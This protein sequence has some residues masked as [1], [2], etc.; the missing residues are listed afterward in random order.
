MFEIKDKHIKEAEDLLINGESFETKERTPFV[1]NLDSCDLLAVPGS[2]KTTALLAKLYCLSKHLPFKDGSGILVLSHTNAAVN[3]IE[4]KLKKVIPSLFEYPNFVGTVQSFVNKFLASLAC[5]I[6]YGS[7]ILNNDNDIYEK[8]AEKFFYSLKWKKTEPKALKNKLFGKVN[9]GKDKIT[10]DEK[11]DNIKTFIKYFDLDI[12]KRKIINNNSSFYTYSGSSK[13]YYLELEQWKE[14]LF[15]KGI[16]NYRDSFYIAEWFAENYPLAITILQK[17]F[18]YVF[19]DEMQDLEKYQIDIIDKIFHGD[20]SLT[21]IQRIGDINQSIYNSSKKENIHADWQVR[22]P[23]MYLND[24]YRLTKEVSDVVNFFTLDRQQDEEGNPRFVVNGKRKLDFVIQP[25]LILFSDDTKGQ[26]KNQFAELIK[27]F[28]LEKTKESEKYGF[29]IIGWN[30]KWDDDEDNKG[31]LRLENIFED[32]KKDKTTLKETYDS[33]SKYLQYLDK[34]KKTLESARKAILNALIHIL[35]IE[36]KM[37]TAII[38]GKER[39]RYYTKKELIKH[40]Q[41][42]KNGSDYETFN[43]NLYK[44]SFDLVAKQKYLEVY[45]SIKDFINNDFKNWFRF[46]ISNNTNEFVGENF[47]ELIQVEE[48][49]EE[50]KSND[51]NIEIGTVHSV[52]GQTHCATMYVETSYHEYETEKER[53]KEALKKEEHTFNLSNG[54]DIRGKQGFRMMYVGF[55]R[56]THLLCFAVLKDNV[57]DEIENYKSADWEIIDL[58]KK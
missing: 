47:E 36:S 34:N 54:K 41:E 5:F 46:A 27:K 30:A 21:I 57:Q 55:S 10:F 40:I 50:K 22:E 13:T 25:H 14:E 29:K 52:K 35:R 53:V 17:R 16:L 38:R 3:E 51:I 39:N 31:K 44:W 32:Y 8:E 23:V 49:Q 9:I 56:P 24:S 11:V 19:I 4:K 58:T 28:G 18:K 2:G 37:Y 1:K 12:S 15:S 45:N 48:R 42:E 33:L 20:K 6:K 7:Y 26:L 43:I